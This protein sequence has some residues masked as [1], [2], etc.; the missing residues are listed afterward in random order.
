LGAEGQTA[1]GDFERESIVQRPST[2]GR[3][4]QYSLAK[5]LGIWALAT[6]PIGFLGWIAFPL[7]APKSGSDPL[8][9]THLE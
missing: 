7:L 6:V 2:R 9:I 5:I 3:G 4:E 1:S 8:D